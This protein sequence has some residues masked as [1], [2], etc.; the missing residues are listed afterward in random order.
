MVR[1]RSS[2]CC[3][4]SRATYNNAGLPVAG[5]VVRFWP[6]SENA[7]MWVPSQCWL[8]FFHLGSSR[9]PRPRPCQPKQRRWRR[10]QPRRPQ[11]SFTASVGC[12]V[13]Q[14][15]HRFDDR[16]DRNCRRFQ[17][18]VSRLRGD[19]EIG[20]QLSLRPPS[21]RAGCAA[22]V[23]EARAEDRHS[24]ADALCTNFATRPPRRRS[25][26]LAVYCHPNS[27]LTRPVARVADDAVWHDQS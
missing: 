2:F 5:M 18:A 22:P 17:T 14:I 6:R 12:A 27:P 26:S 11:T 20:F 16:T 19:A 23:D 4:R 8:S 10:H 1:K 7:A 24:C 13:K 25:S 9:L 21:G 3:R 15:P